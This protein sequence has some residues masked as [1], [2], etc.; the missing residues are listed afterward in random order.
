MAMTTRRLRRSGVAGA[1]LSALVLTGCTAGEDRGPVPDG[2]EPSSLP[3]PT[4]SVAAGQEQATDPAFARFYDQ[5]P[6]W[7]GCAEN[8]ECAK[9][10]VPVDWAAPDGATLDLAVARMPAEDSGGRLGSLL[11]N[12][13]GPGASGVDYVADYGTSVATQAVRQRYDLV[14]FDPRGV[15]QSSP[16]DCVPDPQLDAFNSY[17]VDPDTPQGQAA[18]REV[19]EDFAAGCAARTGDLLGHVDTR[20]AARDM[21]VLRDAVD[22]ERLTYLGKSYG[23]LLGATYADLFPQRAGR[24]VLDGALDPALS[25][26]DLSIGQAAGMDQALRAYVESCQS[27]EGCP[28]RGTADDGMA[29]VRAV[30]Q[31]ADQ[32][33]L[34]TGDPNRPLT[35]S[36][37]FYGVVLPLYDDKGWPVLDQALTQALAGDGTGLL[38]LADLYADRQPDGTYS[39][40]LLEVFPAVNCL[41]YPVD[42][43]PQAMDATAAKLEEAS[44]I[45]GPQLAYGELLCAAWPVPPVRQPAPLHAAGAPPIL[46]IGTTGDPATPYP[47]AQSL[48]RELESGRLLTWEGEGH[49]AYLRGS[50]CVDAAVDGYLLDGVLPGDGATCR[51]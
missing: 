10:T 41:D 40:N 22:D 39:S 23:T 25:S 17:D 30:L 11:V 29:Q 14:G 46:V 5:E 19:V 12:P 27:R 3:S 4:S 34:R 38:R 50:D 7:E 21:D 32:N 35:S 42:A 48:A 24:L 44:P 51:T 6:A 33:P 28:L 20:S 36:L 47:W 16:V 49:T 15:G 45:F 1:L 43:S 13:G 9:V 18:A 37:A 2:G 26:T 8:V 31:Q